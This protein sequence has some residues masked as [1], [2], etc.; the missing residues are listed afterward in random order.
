MTAATWILIYKQP[1][2]A[3]ATGEALKFFAW[4]YKNGAKM[5]QELDYIPMPANVAADVEKSWMS[6]IKDANG[7]PIFAMTN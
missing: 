7:K 1:S 5:A 2:D 6:E 4:A 3:A